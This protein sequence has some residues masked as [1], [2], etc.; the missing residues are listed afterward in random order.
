MR[1]SLTQGTVD[2]AARGEFLAD[3]NG[4]LSLP[5]RSS[6]HGSRIGR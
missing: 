5:R 3:V 4:R 1:E 6:H 2:G